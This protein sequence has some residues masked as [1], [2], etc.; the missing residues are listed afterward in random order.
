MES[1]EK[2]KKH[3]WWHTWIWFDQCDRTWGQTPQTQGSQGAIDVGDP[4][5]EVK[6]V[7]VGGPSQPSGW[8]LNIPIEVDKYK[9]PPR[10]FP[11][12]KS[13][14][15]QTSQQKL[16]PMT[17]ATSSS[18]VSRRKVV[19]K[20]K[21]LDYE[22]EENLLKGLEGIVQTFL[23]I[24]ELRLQTMLKLE[25][26]RDDRKL[27]MT[28]MKLERQEMITKEKRDNEADRV[29]AMMKFKDCQREERKR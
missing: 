23:K 5:E 11:R 4:E 26:D 3:N 10:K 25:A 22:A 29:F 27:A 7:D 9:T 24:E 1:R 28:K 17:P 18:N 14:M 15:E 6:A 21:V 19:Q 13:H 16:T 8:D 2:R 20:R 12:Q